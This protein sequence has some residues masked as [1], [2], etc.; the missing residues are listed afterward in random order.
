[1]SQEPP[2]ASNLPA[3]R[4]APNFART[5]AFVGLIKSSAMQNHYT[6]PVVLEP[7]E[8]GGFQVY[9]PALPEI[10]TWGDDEQH[11]LAMAK[12]AIELVVEDRL[13]NGEP[14]PPLTFHQVTVSVAA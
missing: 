13:A 8:D 4:S 6:Y 2:R 14:L 1:M 3:R 9:V 5:L 7:L 11:A 12:E 10:V